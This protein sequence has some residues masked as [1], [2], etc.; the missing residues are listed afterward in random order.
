LRDTGC[1]TVLIH[2]KRTNP[3]DFTGFTRDMFSGWYSEEVSG[4]SY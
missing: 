2:S 4:S 3:N 1:S